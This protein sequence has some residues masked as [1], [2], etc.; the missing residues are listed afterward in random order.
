MKWL[1]LL[2]KPVLRRV[3]LLPLLPLVA[4]LAQCRAAVAAAGLPVF[5][6]LRRMPCPPS[7]PQPALGSTL[8]AL[9]VLLGPGL[10]AVA[11][12][13][14]HTPCLVPPFACAASL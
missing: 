5:L 12:V 4:A 6:Q 14:A 13:A 2:W 11:V 9:G 1:A 8:L 10:L 3:L 7:P